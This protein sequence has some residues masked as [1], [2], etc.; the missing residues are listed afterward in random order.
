MLK[1]KNR[2][3]LKAIALVLVLSFVL[4]VYAN[5]AVIE[6]PQTRASD[7]LDSYNTYICTMG[8]GKLEIWY[9]V[10]GDTDMDEIGVLSIILYESTDS[11]NWTHVKTYSH[12]NYPSMLVE[13]DFF[14]SSYVSYRGIPG[15]YYKALVCIWA[16]RNGSGDTRYMWTRVERAT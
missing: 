12:E 4:P 16:G 11:T 3:L 5:A 7:Y 13:D 8:G 2:V 9:T 1:L 14:H 10:V 6:G 15:K